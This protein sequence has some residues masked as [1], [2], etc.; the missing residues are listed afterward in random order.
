MERDIEPVPE[1]W[2]VEYNISTGVDIIRCLTVVDDVNH[3]A[4]QTTIE[5][6]VRD[7]E[8]PPGR[9]EVEIVRVAPL[10]SAMEADEMLSESPLLEP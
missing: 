1:E 5:I 8:L 9:I 2:L 7:I 4:L 6:E 3:L 10:P